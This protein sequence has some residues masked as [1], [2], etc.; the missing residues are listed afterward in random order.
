MQEV[1]SRVSRGLGCGC[2][3]PRGGGSRGAGSEG[4][5][6]KYAVKCVMPGGLEVHGLG[7]GPSGVLTGRTA[8]LN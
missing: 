6:D 3:S 2:L 1:S 8:E 4:A 7:K 5:T